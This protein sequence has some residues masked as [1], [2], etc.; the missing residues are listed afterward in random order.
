MSIFTRFTDIVNANLNGML[1]KAENPEKMIRLIVQEMEETLVEVRATAAKSI[2][3]KK[4]LL[5]QV[6]TLENSIANWQEKA[7][8]AVSKAREDLARA[9]LS[10]KQKCQT[11]LSG[12]QQEL[13]Q[14]DVHLDAVQEDS[15]RLQEKLSEAKRKQDAYLIRQQSVEVRLKVKQQG[16]IQQMDSAIAKFE[17][18]Q[19]K[20]DRLEAELESYDFTENKDLESQFREL[21][22]ADKVEQELAELKKQVVNA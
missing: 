13:A 12:L 17:R 8:L 11:K 5:R 4:T 15:Q 20:I 6:R 18:Y 1:D 22:E 21:D 2:A 9:A 16:H 10:E 3:E 19:Q 14:I 7:S